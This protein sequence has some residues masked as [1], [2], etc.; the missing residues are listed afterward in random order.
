L[1][2]IDSNAEAANKN[3]EDANLELQK[4]KQKMIK[5]FTR[6][7]YFIVCLVFIIPFIFYL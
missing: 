3:M 2:N 5:N 7:A 1:D 4:K 6:M